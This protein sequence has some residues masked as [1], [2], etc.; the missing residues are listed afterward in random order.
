VLLLLIEMVVVFDI[1]ISF[2]AGYLFESHWKELDRK[3][4]E[5]EKLYGKD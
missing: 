4:A 5:K 3:M 1:G 2:L